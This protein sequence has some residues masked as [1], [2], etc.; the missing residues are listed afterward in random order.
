MELKDI[1]EAVDATSP[2]VVKGRREPTDVA[3]F[4]KGFA[5]HVG[6]IGDVENRSMNDLFKQIELETASNPPFAG[7]ERHIINRRRLTRR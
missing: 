3:A 4:R 1:R 2:N 5:S 6:T 7:L